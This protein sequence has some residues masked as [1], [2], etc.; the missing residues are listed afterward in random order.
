M[1][2]A[3]FREPPSDAIAEKD[4]PINNGDDARPVGDRLIARG[5]G[6]STMIETKIVALLVGVGILLT[7]FAEQIGQEAFL[8]I[9]AFAS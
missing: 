6:S 2:A 5:Q 8:A 7:V 4:G 9:V 1:V 3:V